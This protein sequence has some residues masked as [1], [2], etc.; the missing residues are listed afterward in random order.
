VL[1]FDDGDDND[2]DHDDGNNDDDGN[3]NDDNNNNDD[4]MNRSLQK[5]YQLSAVVI[6]YSF[7][8]DFI[9]ICA[10]FSG[11]N[12]VQYFYTGLRKMNI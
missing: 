6:Y 10:T 12:G 4:E 2:N 3:N 8:I 9:C 1:Y 5:N 11:L 7:L